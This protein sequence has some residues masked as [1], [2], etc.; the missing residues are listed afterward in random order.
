MLPEL[1]IH[2]IFPYADID[3]KRNMRLLNRYFYEILTPKFTLTQGKDE[4]H[5]E[6]SIDF[7][8]ASYHLF[9]KLNI[10]KL[11]DSRIMDFK[12]FTNITSLKLKRFEGLLDGSFLSKCKEIH[13]VCCH[14]IDNNLF[15]GISENI[16]VFEYS[17]DNLATPHI[18]DV[19]K[20]VNCKVLIL[21]NSNVES[22]EKLSS[23][24]KLTLFDWVNFDKLTTH[25]NFHY[26]KIRHLECSGRNVKNL[27]MFT[28]KSSTIDC[29]YCKQL[30][31]DSILSIKP[32]SFI[33]CECK[34]TNLNHL[35]ENLTVLDCCGCLSLTDE[36]IRVLKPRLKKLD[37]S[38]CDIT[39]LND[40]VVCEYLACNCCNKLTD[41]SI[42]KLGKCLKKLYC[43]GCNFTDFNHLDN[44]IEIDCYECE[45]INDNSI[46]KIGK[47][48]KSFACS[49]TQ[50]TDLNCLVNCEE[51]FCDDCLK[52]TDSSIKNI[53]K[54]KY[55]SC[56]GC[57]ITDFNHLTK[58]EELRWVLPDSMNVPDFNNV[59]KYMKK[60]I[61]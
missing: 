59:V 48:I 28:F 12:K 23:L 2:E 27:N 44:C 9:T 24:E 51:L 61:K 21:D 8:P 20:L 54:L 18:T 16:E 40:L 19:S 4:L 25:E 6:I 37:C 56:Y 38:N 42:A 13:L 17:I 1:I 33:C 52:L 43:E 14:E 15:N 45:F 22:I 39:D 10:I 32:Q 35:E 3:D 30:T 31:N 29:S 7:L 58:L 46:I 47:N 34:F 5:C 50:L 41:K 36:S 53:T 49:R 60:Q 57:K 11:Y 26:E 55:L